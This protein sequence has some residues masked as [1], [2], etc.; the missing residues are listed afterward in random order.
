MTV[1]ERELLS[2]FGRAVGNRNASIFVGAGLSQ[3]AGFPG[4][5]ELLDEPRKAADIPE[6]VRDLA[7][8]AQYYVQ[9]VPGGPETL[10]DHV[11][12]ALVKVPV[13]PTPAHEF[14]AEVPVDDVWTTNY[15]CLLE[16][17]M[18]GATVL[19]SEEEVRTRPPQGRKRIIK[20]HGSLTIETPVRWRAPPVITREHYESYEREYPRLWA[21]LRA[22]YLTKSM[23]FL[24]FSFADPNVEVL[25]RLSRTLQASREHFTVLR[26]PTE[27]SERRLHDLRRHDLE[28]SGVQVCEIDDY[29]DLEP[30]LQR[31]A[32][33]TR[34]TML[35]V[36]GSF[37]SDVQANRDLARSIGVNLADLNLSVASLGGTA[38]LDISFAFGRA[39]QAHDEYAAERVKIFFRA[40]AGVPP[41][42]LPERIGTV[43]YT[44]F[45][46]E[47][48]R[49]HVLA[50]CR[51]LLL[52][53]GR[54]NTAEEVVLARRL[55]LPVVPVA[56]SGGTARD[57][58]QSHTVES[59]G[60]NAD[61]TEED[62]RN[63]AL[64]DHE[65]PSLCAKVV[66]R[67]VVQAMYLREPTGSPR[68]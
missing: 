24:G 35:F 39:L 5:A 54:A 34:D 16:A 53:G 46:K 14:L 41:D 10:Q 2:A 30:M 9:S 27:P 50:Q 12:R 18:A 58:W 15:D 43:I 47:K 21:L 48:M 13:K 17:S 57:V 8:A 22:T 45:D 31:L 65:D 68:G 23:L 28:Q 29:A 6:D 66:Q 60:V 49:N 3:A 19:A 52:L 64:L 42:P 61:A 26:R 40:K 4:W 38:A 25:L 20:M 1:S 32:R 51:A 36:S 55:G 62:R 44:N 59:S 7:L 56:R 33:R 11:L 37:S 67:L 63:W